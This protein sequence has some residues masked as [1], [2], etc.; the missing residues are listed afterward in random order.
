MKFYIHTAFEPL[1]KKHLP[2]FSCFVKNIHVRENIMLLKQYN[3]SDAK[4]D[5]TVH[6][7]TLFCALS[8]FL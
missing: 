8:Q 6:L 3:S 4:V 2:F 7:Q 1:A 5:E